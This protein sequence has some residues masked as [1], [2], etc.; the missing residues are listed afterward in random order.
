M[1]V[2]LIVLV[3]ISVCATWVINQHPMARSVLVS[4][5]LPR[6]SAD[7]VLLAVVLV[8]VDW[9]RTLNSYIAYLSFTALTLTLTLTLLTLTLTL[10]LTL[11]LHQV[12]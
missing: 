7:A 1:V 8:T 2:A 4:F 5:L 6:R 9:P 11:S 12:C 10:T 3:D